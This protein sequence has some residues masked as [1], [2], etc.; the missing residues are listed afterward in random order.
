MFRERCLGRRDHGPRRFDPLELFLLCLTQLI[1]ISFERLL[2]P[3]SL[4]RFGFDLNANR[5]QFG[6]LPFLFLG[7]NSRFRAGLSVSFVSSA[8]TRFGS[9]DALLLRGFILA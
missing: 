5:L 8:K 7:A 1:D 6:E 4:C 9:C 2:G 3:M